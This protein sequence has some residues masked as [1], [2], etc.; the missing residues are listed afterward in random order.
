MVKCAIC[1]RPV[2]KPGYKDYYDENGHRLC[3]C[4]DCCLQI[5][6]FN[7]LKPEELKNDIRR[8]FNEMLEIIDDESHLERA[9]EILAFYKIDCK[10]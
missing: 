5:D 3:L 4:F 2:D 1:N 9:K 7:Q 6:M 8:E 10:S